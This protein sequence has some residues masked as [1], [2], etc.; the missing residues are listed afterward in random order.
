MAVVN[1]DVYGGGLLNGT[2]GN[3]TAGRRPAHP[4]EADVVLA[5]DQVCRWWGTDLATAVLLFSLRDPGIASTVTGFADPSAMTQTLAA[6]DD[7][8][9]EAFWDELDSLMPRP[10]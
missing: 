4:A 1:A 9:V 5:M 2:G 8:L 3:H 6:L 7:D 10:E